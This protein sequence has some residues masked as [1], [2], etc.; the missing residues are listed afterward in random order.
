M[1]VGTG[2]AVGE[3][4][5]SGVIVFG[6]VG[7]LAAAQNWKKVPDG[8]GSLVAVR[9]MAVGEKVRSGVTN[10]GVG[11]VVA[12]AQNWPLTAHT[13]HAGRVRCAPASGTGRPARR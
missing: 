1:G 11:A 8:A 12:A 4:V 6:V 10:L 5:R 7:G 9:R 13:R 2:V 3:K